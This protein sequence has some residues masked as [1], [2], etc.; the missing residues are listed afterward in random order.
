MT[1]GAARGTQARLVDRWYGGRRRIHRNVGGGVCRGLRKPVRPIGAVGVRVGALLDAKE[2]GTRSREA[3]RPAPPFAE[4]QTPSRSPSAVPPR[5]PAPGSAA[6]PRKHAEP[7]PTAA[8]PAQPPGRARPPETR[9]LTAAEQ[10]AAALAE[11]PRM[12]TED[13]RNRVER[14]RRKLHAPPA[15][16]EKKWLE[17]CGALGKLAAEVSEIAIPPATS[18]VAR[19]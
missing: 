8:R 12:M 5:I 4:A 3:P 1:G 13:A 17:T 11:L 2:R 14:F 18:P 10:A 7:G 15:W 19:Y 9:P 16:S 6:I